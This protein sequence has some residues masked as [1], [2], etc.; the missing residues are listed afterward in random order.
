[1]RL[2]GSRLL[3]DALHSTVGIEG[4]DAV[5]LGIGDVIGEHGRPVDS[6]SRLLQHRANAGA[7]E[8]VVAQDERGGIAAQEVP[9][10]EKCLGQSLGFRLLGVTEV[11]AELRA[12]AEQRAKPWHILRRRD[13][14]HVPDAREHERGERI[15]HERL[16]VHRHQLLRDAEGQ[17]VEPRA[18]AAGQDDAFSHSR[19]SV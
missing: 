2:G 14:Q 4:N 16:V 5:A 3:L 10:D 1:V 12:V 9:P 17:R 11:E 7:V 15:V 8:D 13:E 6:F 19:G 18:G